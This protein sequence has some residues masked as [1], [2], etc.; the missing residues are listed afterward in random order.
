MRLPRAARARATWPTPRFA[1]SPRA[2]KRTAIRRWLPEICP[3][4]RPAARRRIEAFVAAE[5]ASE[6]LRWRRRYRELADSGYME[7]SLGSLAELAAGHDVELAHPFH[8]RRF[9]AALA[10]LPPAA[11]PGLAARTP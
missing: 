3:W 8:D 5:A 4:L 2:V 11:A 9:L 6:P 7:V 10:A 1:L